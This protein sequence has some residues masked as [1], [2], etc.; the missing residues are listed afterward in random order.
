MNRYLAVLSGA[1]LGGLARY[2]I[3]TAITARLGGRFPFGTLTINITGSFLAG[4]VMILLTERLAAHDNWRLFLV[5]GFLG[6]YTTFSAMEYETF[7]AVRAREGWTAMG[8]VAASVILGYA[9]VWLGAW[10]AGKR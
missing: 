7:L 10:V 3:G 2:I 9:A 6:G 8:Y 4:A 1:G 5:V